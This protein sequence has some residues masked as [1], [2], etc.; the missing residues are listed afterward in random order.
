MLPKLLCPMCWHLYAG[1]VS[2]GM[3]KGDVNYEQQT[4]S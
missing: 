3:K 4:N 2:S 1:I